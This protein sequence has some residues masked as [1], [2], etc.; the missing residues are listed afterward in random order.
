[1]DNKNDVFMVKDWFK[2][3]FM[4]VTR[5]VCCFLLEYWLALQAIALFLSIV[6]CGSNF[7][8]KFFVI[9]ENSKDNKFQKLVLSQQVFKKYVEKNITEVIIPTIESVPHFTIL[10]KIEYFVSEFILLLYIGVHIA[11]CIIT[12]KV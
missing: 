1:M 11:C 3:G 8:E 12:S 5:L 2:C 4:F 9:E 10:S 6:I 7:F